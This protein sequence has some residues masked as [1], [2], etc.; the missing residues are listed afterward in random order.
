MEIME[1]PK[2]GLELVGKLIETKRNNNAK[3]FLEVCK[4]FNVGTGIRNERI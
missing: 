1:D 4:K 3:H 2:P